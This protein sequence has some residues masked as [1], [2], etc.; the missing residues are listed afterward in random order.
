MCSGYPTQIVI[1][2]VL[3]AAGISP[4]TAD[5]ALSA[6]FVFALSLADTVVL[7][8]LIVL[9]LR[10]NGEQPRRVFFGD[11]RV[12]PEIAYGIFS[13]PFV[14]MLVIGLTLLLRAFAPGLRN[15]P[16]NPLEG[17][18]GTQTGLLAF[19]FVVIVAG[20]LREELQRAFLLHRFRHDL[21]SPLMGLLITSLAFGLGH[22]LQGWDA[23][24][25]TG[26]LGATWGALYLARG[27]AVASI[28][29]HSLF[30]SG[31]LLRAFFR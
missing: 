21:R 9:L 8:T 2:E 23:A 31:E 6:R 7:L 30:N 28:V 25:L 17:L 24:I 16:I 18:L 11:A 4:L 27:S 5:G 12:G 3:K 13:V 22:T 15:V 29:S 10:R 20:G 26:A 19:L 14:V 1:G